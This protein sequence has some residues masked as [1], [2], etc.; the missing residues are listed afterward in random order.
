VSPPPRPVL[1]LALSLLAGGAAAAGAGEAAALPAR[2]TLATVVVVSAR[3]PVVSEGRAV[4][5]VRRGR[6][7]GVLAREGERVSVQVC[8][9]AAPRR[10]WLEARHVRPV[11][12]G[13]VD[14]AWEA[15]KIAREL[16][17]QVDLM[18]SWARL[19]ALA[20]RVA[21]AAAGGRTARERARR[22]AAQLY[23]RERFTY[24]HGVKRLDQV[25]AT[26]RGDCVG[27][28]LLYLRVARELRMPLYLVTWP[29]HVLVRHDDGTDRFHIETTERGAVRN[30]DDPVQHR[31]GRV[32]GGIHCLALPAP[33][34]LGVLTHV[35]G[36]LLA[37]RGKAAEACARFATA[38]EINPRDVEALTL[39]GAALHKRGRYAEACDRYQRVV[40]IDPGHSEVRLRWGM[41]LNQ[42]GRYAEACGKCAEAV[43]LA[44]DYADG[45]HAWGFALARLGRHGEACER[46]AK[47]V[48]LRPDFA[49]AHAAWGASLGRIGKLAEANASHAKAVELEP[50]NAR[51][52]LAWAMTLAQAGRRAEALERLDR[53]ALLDPALKPKAD[54]LRHTLRPPR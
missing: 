18:A 53:A 46:F 16:D 47:A 21:A 22:I 2:R 35:W 6:M 20:T 30:I 7:F 27:L 50:L 49:A 43:K 12:D 37:E 14:L 28:C 39:W 51:A 48:A 33:R 1:G 5:A 17:P 10:G 34:A 13:E 26:R 4:A 15:L 23:G 41:A 9:G 24:A 54:K 38:C 29:S 45:W 8:E 19:E 3:A 42:M 11:T 44:P 40:A 25:L 31:R 36:T 52:H 32:A